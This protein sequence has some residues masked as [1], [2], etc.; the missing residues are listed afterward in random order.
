M[1]EVTQGDVW[2]RKV[3]TLPLSPFD[4]R[5]RTQM[6]AER[7]LAYVLRVTPRT[8]GSRTTMA[9]GYSRD[10]LGKQVTHE[11][12]ITAFRRAF[13]LIFPAL[14]GPLPP[15]ATSSTAD[16]RPPADSRFKKSKPL[17]GIGSQ[18]AGRADSPAPTLH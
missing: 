18:A 6:P 5:E 12:E 2:Q 3:G 17:R 7:E 16:A 9:V 11:L 10:P 8:I 4:R 13:R 15:S 1:I 14:G